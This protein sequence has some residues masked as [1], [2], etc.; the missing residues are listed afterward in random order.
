MDIN[1]MTRKQFEELPYLDEF[2]DHNLRDI[3]VVLY[4]EIDKQINELKGKV[5]NDQ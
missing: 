3:D 4:E 1:K 5:K 2:E